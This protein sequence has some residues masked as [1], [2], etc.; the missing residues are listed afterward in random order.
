MVQPVTFHVKGAEQLQLL[1]GAC[2]FFSPLSVDPN[3]DESIQNLSSVARVTEKTVFVTWI[4]VA[5][6][7]LDFQTENNGSDFLN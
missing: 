6:L 7:V 2:P 4:N 5:V 1:V 3:R